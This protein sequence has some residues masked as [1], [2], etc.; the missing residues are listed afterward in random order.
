VIVVRFKTSS[1]SRS[2]ADVPATFLTVI[3]VHALPVDGEFVTA[4][5]RAAAAVPVVPPSFTTTEYVD[6]D[7]AAFVVESAKV[8]SIPDTSI[9]AGALNQVFVSLITA[10]V[11]TT[12]PCEMAFIVGNAI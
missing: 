9:G 4:V 6:A 2:V 10:T 3:S 7:A 12:P 5:N 1:A 11:V 8:N